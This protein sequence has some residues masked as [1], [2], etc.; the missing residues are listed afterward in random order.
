VNDVTKQTAK[1]RSWEGLWRET[2]HTS[3]H[4]TEPKYIQ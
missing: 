4:F 1:N 2:W 3:K